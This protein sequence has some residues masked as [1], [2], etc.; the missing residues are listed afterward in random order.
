MA[1]SLT[2][3]SKIRN[4]LGYPD[5][6]RYKN[7]RLE[8]IM[9]NDVSTE[10]ENLI[11]SWLG[12][13]DNFDSQIGTIASSTDTTTVSSGSLK[14]VEDIEWYPTSTSTSTSSDGVGNTQKSITDWQRF[15]AGKI[16]IALGVPFYSDAFGTEGYDGDS[17]SELG[18][19]GR[20]RRNL[21]P[22]G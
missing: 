4:L 16:S 3:K 14:R 1:L 12:Q 5:S 10:T 2:E 20:G 17:F 9:E 18:G 8:S 6:F 21:I 11:R 19:L 7:T 22:L 15:F 13:L